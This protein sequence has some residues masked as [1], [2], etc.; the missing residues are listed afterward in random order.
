MVA[1]LPITNFSRGEFGP[2]LYGR[3]DLPQYGAG[4]KQLVNFMVQ[5]YGGVRF[6]DGFRYVAPILEAPD[7]LVTLLPFQYSIEQAYVLVMKDNA[8][9]V[10]AQGGMV[11]EEDLKITAVVASDTAV[12]LTVPYH[13]YVVGDVIYFSGITGWEELNGRFVSVIEI[14]DANQFKVSIASTGWGTF[15]DSTGITRSGTPPVPPAPE[16]PPPPPPPPPDPPPLGS[17][18]GTAPPP[19]QYG[20]GGGYGGSGGYTPGGGY[21]S[22]GYHPLE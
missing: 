12:T 21:G 19:E 6:R 1:R 16:P 5:R 7:K 8:M 17:G 9:T 15:T 18:G 20:G 4:A 2:Q 22:D 3:V 13:D 14:V 11:L 10:A